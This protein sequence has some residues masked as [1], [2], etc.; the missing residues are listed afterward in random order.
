MSP[1]DDIY[2]IKFGGNAI[3]GKDDLTRLSV[4][5]AELIRGGD[6]IILVHGGG[7]EIS[8]EMERLGMTSRKVCGIRVTD[9]ASLEVA[10]LVLRRFNADVVGCLR[11]SGVQALGIP[12]YF[13]TVCTRKPSMTVIENGREREVDLGLVGEVSGTNPQYLFDLLAK[14]IT[15]VIYPISKDAE[16][17]RLNVNADTMVAGI[18]AGVSCKEMIMITDVPGILLDV[19]NS[20]SKAD[21]LTLVEVDT[22]ITDGIISG[23]MIPKV[24]ACRK[25]LLAGVSVVRMINGKDP[26]SIITDIKRGVPHGTV[27]T[28]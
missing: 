28:K 18:A 12:G 24:E 23:G 20:G 10:E 2:V 25:A 5:I 22:L 26:R 14:G 6:R 1:M 3:R 8:E 4:E 9:E 11:E 17:R 15:P 27:I 7:P 16:G 21:S 13:C 19:S